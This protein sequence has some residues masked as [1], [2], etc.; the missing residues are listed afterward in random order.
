MKSRRMFEPHLV[1]RQLSLLPAGEWWPDSPGWL[2]AQVT[3]G[4]VCSVHPNM[5]QDLPTGAVIIFADSERGYLRAN[6]SDG[7]TVHHFLVDPARLLG[8]ITF[9]EQQSLMKISQQATHPP[10]V[11]WPDH[12]ISQQFRQIYSGLIEH[13]VSSRIKLLEIF[14]ESLREE[15]EMAI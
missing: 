1:M 13:R 10:R 14:A 15:M 12:A 6:H 7:A 8:L 3:S 5:N 11:L 4:E 2:F 9:R